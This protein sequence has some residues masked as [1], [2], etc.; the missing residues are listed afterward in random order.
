VPV[1]LKLKGE[2]YVVGG[3]SSTR[4][5]Y[6]AFDKSDSKVPDFQEFFHNLI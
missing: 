2:C 5:M 3:G 6:V 4:F 1:I